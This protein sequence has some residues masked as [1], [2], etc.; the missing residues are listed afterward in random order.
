[1]I[2]ILAQGIR[3][4]LLKWPAMSAVRRKTHKSNG[5]PDGIRTRV[6]TVKGW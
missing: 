3:L 5:V 2:M 4:V 6:P 1:M